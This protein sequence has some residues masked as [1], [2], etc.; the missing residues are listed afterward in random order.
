MPKLAKRKNKSGWREQVF[1]TFLFITAVVFVPTTLMLTIGMLPAIVASFIDKSKEKMLGLTVGAMN[2]AGC[3]PFVLQLWTTSHTISGAVEILSDPL[4]IVIMYF[5][6]AFGYMLEWSLTGM[7]VVFVT[8]KAKLRLDEIE[9]TQEDLVRKW[10]PEVTGK[11]KLGEDGFPLESE[12]GKNPDNDGNKEENK[13]K[14][15][16]KS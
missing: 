16:K 1:L 6:A 4:T 11:I 9:K 12:T 7:V 3:T 5:A 8:E 13:D 10:G 2:L 14:N 15:Q